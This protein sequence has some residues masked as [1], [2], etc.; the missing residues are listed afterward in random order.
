[1][2][3]V[4][5]FWRLVVNV[6][7]AAAVVVSWPTCLCFNAVAS[8]GFERADLEVWWRRGVVE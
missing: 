2:I 6:V 7:A 3:A 5:R 8:S 4:K 1:L